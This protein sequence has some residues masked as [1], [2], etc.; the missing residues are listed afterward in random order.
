[1][2]NKLYHLKMSE[3]DENAP[4]L[5]TKGRVVSTACLHYSA[6]SAGGWGIVRTALLVPESIML[7]VGPHGCGRHG[8]VS[9]IQLGLR[10]RIYYMD[11]TE[12]DLV[13]GDHVNRIDRVVEDILSERKQKPAAFLICATCI[14]DLLATDYKNIVRR[15]TKKYGIPFADCHMNPITMNSALPPTLNVQRSIYSFLCDTAAARTEKNTVNLIGHFTPVH[16]ESEIFPVLKSAGFDKVL[17][18]SKCTGFDEFLEMRNSGHNI[19]IK[20]FGRIACQDMEKS[21]GIPW[22]KQLIRYGIDGIKRGYEEISA[23]LGRE[24]D[25]LKYYEDCREEIESYRKKLKGLRI[26]VGEGANGSPFEI[27]CALA[28]YGADIAFVVCS[29]IGDYEW[30][31]VHKLKKMYGEIPVYTNYH[32][33]MAVI[34]AIPETADVALGFD[35]SYMCPAA[36]LFSLDSDDQHYGFE[37]ASALLRGIEGALESNLSARELLYS[38]GLVV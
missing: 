6:P 26:G 8:S 14:D 3:L 22:H 21:L 33:S 13:L 29:A 19:L 37:A 7:F 11:V 15:L 5:G 30:E 38:K 36:K 10:N 23:F 2:K 17:Q 18:L 1:M 20:P 16:Q 25:I 31:Y 24:L 12:E 9:S 27:A 4:E 34:D 28:E 32:P 35:A